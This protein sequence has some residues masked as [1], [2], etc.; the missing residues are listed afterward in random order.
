MPTLKKAIASIRAY[1]LLEYLEKQEKNEDEKK[2]WQNLKDIFFQKAYI[3]YSKALEYAQTGKEPI[4]S[5]ARYGPDVTKDWGYEGLIYM[6]SYLSYLVVSKTEQDIERKARFYE[7]IRRTLAKLV[8]TGK[9]SKS[10]PS[11]LI[12]F[13]RQ[14]H[15]KMGNILKEIYEKHPELKES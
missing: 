5:N 15:E 1:W 7:Q 14:L 9:A 3:F 6:T 10:K 4:G 8:G 11:A 12:E 13:A 2:K